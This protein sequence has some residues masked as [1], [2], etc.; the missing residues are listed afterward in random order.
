MYCILIPARLDS[1]RLPHKMLLPVAG[2]PAI[3]WV[4]ETAIATGL[5]FHLVTDDVRIAEAADADANAIYIQNA[6]NGTERCAKALLRC[7]DL[8]QYDHFII[9]SGDELCARP[10]HIKYMAQVAKEDQAH[11]LTLLTGAETKANYSYA[12]IVRHGAGY[13]LHISR[14][15]G[16]AYEATGLYLYPRWMLAG[17]AYADQSEREIDEGIEIL[18]AETMG[19]NIHCMIDDSHPGVTLNE[20]K[21]I[22]I[23]EGILREQSRA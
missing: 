12:G 5:P 11:L 18:R 22:A 16:G 2:K 10:E 23:I 20:E 15:P 21:D 3:R 14:E 19:L 9:L 1:T 6:A 13:K 17:Y 4:V 8:R 7:P